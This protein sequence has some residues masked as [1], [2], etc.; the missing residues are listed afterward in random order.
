[1]SQLCTIN[2]QFGHPN[3]V[4]GLLNPASGAN[5]ISISWSGGN[6]T[7]QGIGASYTGV[8][9]SGLPDATATKNQNSGSTISHTITTVAD[10]CWVAAFVRASADSISANSN[11]T[12]RTDTAS[13][14]E[15][16]WGDSN[17]AV[18]PAGNYT[19]TVNV[20]SGSNAELLLM[21]SFAPT[22]TSQGSVIFI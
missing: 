4:Y 18:T 6:T 13:A 11:I 20:N 15:S 17:G 12:M 7:M 5:N 14:N 3:Y 19:M 8:L 16:A 2:D 21:V 10:N 9:Q 22:V 1:M